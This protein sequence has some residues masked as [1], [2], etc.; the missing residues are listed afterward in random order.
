MRSFQINKKKLLE[1]NLHTGS[2]SLNLTQ[3]LTVFQGELRIGTLCI[4]FIFLFMY[5]KY[6]FF[7]LNLCFIYVI[8]YPSYPCGV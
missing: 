6:T 2:F 5:T 8:C 1:I 4:C 3:L 7:N